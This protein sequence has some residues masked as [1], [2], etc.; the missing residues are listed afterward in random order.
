MIIYPRG[1]SPWERYCP[2]SQKAHVCSHRDSR[3]C[4]RGFLDGRT[5]WGW[6][7][8]S[9]RSQLAC[10]SSGECHLPCA[11]TEPWWRTRAVQSL[12]S[13]NHRERTSQTMNEPSIFNSRVGP[14]WR[15]YQLIFRRNLINLKIL[16]ICLRYC[17]SPKTFQAGV[18]PRQPRQKKTGTGW[19]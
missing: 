18:N 5:W 16:H 1:T 9:D 13:K 2:V 15:S 19:W 12:Q 10:G 3:E 7:A 14:L 11:W 4:E 6:T 8:L 17:L